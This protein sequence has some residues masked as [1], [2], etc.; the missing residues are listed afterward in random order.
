MI[1]ARGSADRSVRATAADRL[2]ERSARGSDGIG[3]PEGGHRLGERGQLESECGAY[4]STFE[5]QRAH[6]ALD[7]GRDPVGVEAV[8]A[9]GGLEPRGPQYHPR[10]VQ[11]DVREVT[12]G[13]ECGIGLEKFEEFQEGDVIEAYHLEKRG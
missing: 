6:H 4:R 12:A 2:A 10:R 3:R 7:R 1:H 9:G 8:P 13:L 5:I 11:D